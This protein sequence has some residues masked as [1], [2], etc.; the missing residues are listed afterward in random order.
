MSLDGPSVPDR[1]AEEVERVASDLESAG[2]TPTVEAVRC[3]L[4]VAALDEAFRHAVEVALNGREWLRAYE[5][6]HESAREM[7]GDHAR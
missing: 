1:L 2:L 7:N 6:R 3:R 4:S 5:E